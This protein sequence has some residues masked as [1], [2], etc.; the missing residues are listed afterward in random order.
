MVIIIENNIPYTMDVSYAEL[1]RGYEIYVRER[2][3][4]RLACRNRYKPT[5]RPRG[6]P[7]KNSPATSESD[8]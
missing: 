1:K 8:S 5:G 3:A 6:R 2:E 4:N 7:K